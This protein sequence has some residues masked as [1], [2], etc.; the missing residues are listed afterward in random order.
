MKYVN[1]SKKIEDQ[2]FVFIIISFFLSFFFYKGRLG[3]DDLQSFIFA[4]NL[5]ETFNYNLPDYLQ[6]PSNGWQF[7][8]R[9]IWILQN[10]ILIS[11]F[12]VV[13]SFIF[14]DL[15]YFSIRPFGLS[16]NGIPPLTPSSMIISS[17]ARLSFLYRTYSRIRLFCA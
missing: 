10:T 9:K 8:H 6:D 17:L 13:N 15:K 5:I 14:F 11:I 1:L 16:H 4:F 2:N 3:G 12:K 7:S